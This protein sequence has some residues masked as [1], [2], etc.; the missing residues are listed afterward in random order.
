[1]P[2]TMSW[3]L[4][5]ASMLRVQLVMGTTLNAPGTSPGHHTG[6][7]SQWLARGGHHAIIMSEVQLSSAM[8]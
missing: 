4:T 8:H 2:G 6:H 7:C 5:T 1:M 3:G